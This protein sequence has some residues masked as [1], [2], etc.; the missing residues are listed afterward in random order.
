[1]NYQGISDMA[2]IDYEAMQM[3]ITA[4]MWEKDGL[5]FDEGLESGRSYQVTEEYIFDEISAGRLEP[6]YMPDEEYKE[7]SAEDM[8]RMRQEAEDREG[9]VYNPD[10]DTYDRGIEDWEDSE[11]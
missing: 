11:G 6:I 4:D 9:D 8:E 10:F 2:G 1:M 7:Y 5:T 3:K